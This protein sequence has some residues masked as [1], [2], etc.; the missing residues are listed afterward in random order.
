MVPVFGAQ[1]LSRGQLQSMMHYKKRAWL[2]ALWFNVI[3]RDDNLAVCY[4]GGGLK[5]CLSS[6]KFA[7]AD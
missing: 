6:W 2:G 1:N 7:E 5:S 4:F 3:R